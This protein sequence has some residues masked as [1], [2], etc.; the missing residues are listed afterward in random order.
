MHS[1]PH[2]QFAIFSSCPPKQFANFSTLFKFRPFKSMSYKG[3]GRATTRNRGERVS[4][5]AHKWVK[6]GMEMGTFMFCNAKGEGVS[7]LGRIIPNL[8]MET[9]PLHF[10]V[11][12]G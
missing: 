7:F 10:S 6:L 11:Q 3:C 5:L 1:I 8:G 12:K 4:F 2:Q 9:P